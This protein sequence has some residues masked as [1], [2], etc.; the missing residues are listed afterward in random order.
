MKSN[1]S[2]SGKN[3]A[4][5]AKVP[6]RVLIPSFVAVVALI[7]LWRQPLMLVT[8]QENGEWLASTYRLEEDAP[9]H[10]RLK[11]LRQREKLDDVIAPGKTEFEKIVLLRHWVHSQWTYH[12]K[13]FC[14][15]AWDAVEILDLARRIGNE[16][17]CAQY[18]I[19]LLQ[20]CQSLGLHARYVELPG[21][22]VVAVWSDDYN[23]W[24]VMDPLNDFYFERNGEP[25][26]GR[27]L[28]RA[29]WTKNFKGIVHV[30]FD[31]TRTPVT[32]ADLEVYKKYSIVPRANQLTDPAE[33][34]VDDQPRRQ[35]RLEKD[36]HRYPIVGRNRITIASPYIAWKDSRAKEY[37]EDMP[38]S[39][40]EDEFTYRMNQS[41]VFVARRNLKHGLAKLILWSENTPDFK[42]FLYR[43]N[44]GEWKTSDSKEIFWALDPG[45]NEI[46]VRA[47]TEAGWLT[48]IS[49]CSIFYK[50]AWWG[51]L[52]HTTPPYEGIQ[53]A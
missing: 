28:C 21:H 50:P 13:P 29:Y 40:D 19:V 51:L 35:L 26:V 24:V 36:F 49:R 38:M 18:A 14:Y 25:L 12:N 31:G 17:F 39:D 20:A 8:H 1:G 42:E 37:F 2:K 27:A 7:L 16:G 48:K 53:K 15:P 5:D 10:P 32:L 3:S 52:S 11:L 47:R 46:Q 23:R 22:F 30:A 9:S 6:Y 45:R 4:P 44:G 34:I 41:F 33:I 43:I